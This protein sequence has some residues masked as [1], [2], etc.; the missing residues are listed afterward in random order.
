MLSYLLLLAAFLQ[1][2]LPVQ[3]LCV[4]LLDSVLCDDFLQTRQSHFP[5]RP[6]PPQQ[7]GI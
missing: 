5:V 4:L 6:Q 1:A 2:F 3:L 7:C